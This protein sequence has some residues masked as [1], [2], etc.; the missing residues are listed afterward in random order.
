MRIT[1]IRAFRD[2]YIWAL[3]LADGRCLIVDPGDAEPVLEW[4]QQDPRRCLV[5]ILITHD[6]ADHTG[7]VEALVRQYQCPVFGPQA[8]RI[9]ARTHALS[10]GDRITPAEGFPEFAILA[11]PGH[12]LGHIAFYAKPWL[13]CGDT[14]F[15]SGCGRMF[16][17]TPEQFTETLRRLAELPDAT[18][19][20][21]AHEYTESNLGF[22]LAVEPKNQA[23]KERQSHVAA[24][25][26]LNIPSIPTLMVNEK[27]TN[28]FLRVTQE[29]VKLAAQK[30]ANSRLP[31]SSEVFAVIREWKDNF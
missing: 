30:R 18:Q 4:L 16:E 25:R 12:T 9:P 15:A 22:A 7:G 5:G 6:H 23:V 2:N 14:L 10:H 27:A 26:R 20:F 13:F 24:L 29:S 11:C 17:G 1:P 3:S 28:P 21:C 8:E 19:V 31:S